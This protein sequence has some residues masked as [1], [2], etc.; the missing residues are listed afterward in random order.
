[1]YFKINHAFYPPTLFNHSLNLW[2]AIFTPFRERRRALRLFNDNSVE[3]LN[4]FLVKKEH[5]VSEKP[6]RHYRSSV[7]NQKGAI[8]DFV[9]RALLVLNGTSLSCNNALLALN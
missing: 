7:E 2:D 6:E 1:M 9:Q 4:G 5:I 3:N 8:A